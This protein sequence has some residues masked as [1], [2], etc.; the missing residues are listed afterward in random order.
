AAGVARLNEMLQDALNPADPT[1]RKPEFVRGS[2]RFRPADRVIQLKNNYDKNVYNGD[3][4]SIE[5]ILPIDQQIVVRFPDAVVR[6]DYSEY[7]ELQ[8]AY[9]LSIHKSQGS[10]YPAVVLVIHSS[11]YMMLQRNLLYTGFTRAKKLCI[12]VGNKKAIG[13]AVHNDRASKR[14]TRLADRLREKEEYG[15]QL[16]PRR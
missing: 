15:F 6:Y 5:Q 9:A 14:Y 12:V 2:R 7:D 16:T 11:Q 13:R 1:G 10:E 4:G 8:L 3:I